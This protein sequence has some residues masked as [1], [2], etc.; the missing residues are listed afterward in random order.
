LARRAGVTFKL[1]NNG[2]RTLDRVKVV[3]YFKD[4][5]GRIIA[6]EDYL[7]VLVSEYRYSSDNKPLRPGYIWQ[8][9]RGRF[10]SAKSVPSEWKDGAAE[11]RVVDASFAKTE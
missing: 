3:I 9:E 8:M 6:E 11:A 7:P 5:N 10:Y 1:R 4:A 2:R